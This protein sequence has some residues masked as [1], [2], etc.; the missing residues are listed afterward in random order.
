MPREV[1]SM[2]IKEVI[3]KGEKIDVEFKSW[4]KIKDKKGTYENY[5]KRSGSIGKY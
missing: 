5:Y 4:K 2:D 3:S 1:K